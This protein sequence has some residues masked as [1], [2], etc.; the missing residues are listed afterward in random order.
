MQMFAVST[1]S[2]LCSCSG[3]PCGYGLLRCRGLTLRLE[4]PWILLSAWV[5]Q[6]VPHG[7]TKGWGQFISSDLI[8]TH[9]HPILLMGVLTP[10]RHVL[11]ER[12]VG[13]H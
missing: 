3:P 1:Q 8:H 12:D 10:G 13:D 9:T 11:M 2:V 4:H 7:Y 6:P 5:L